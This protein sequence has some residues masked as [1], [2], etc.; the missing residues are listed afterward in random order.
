MSLKGDKPVVLYSRYSMDDFYSKDF[1]YASSFFSGVDFAEIDCEKVPQ[2]CNDISYMK[3]DTWLVK[4]ETISVFSGDMCAYDFV[5]FIESKTGVVKSKIIDQAKPLDD[6]DWKKV[7]SLKQCTTVFFFSLK[8]R[9]SAILKKI[10]DQVTYSFSRDPKMNV[11]Y[12]DCDK[13]L[14]FC[15]DRG[16]YEAPMIRV[17]KNQNPYDFPGRRYFKDIM[18]FIC[19]TTERCRYGNGELTPESGVIRSVEGLVKK[20]MKNSDKESVINE[21][22]RIT[23]SSTYTI[24]MKGLLKKGESYLENE[25]KKLEKWRKTDRTSENIIELINVMNIF[26]KYRP[27]I[28]SNNEL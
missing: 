7:I 28:N 11:F 27:Y 9:Q 6:N 4:S 19:A 24:I 20:F 25:L 16:V 1:A 10:A 5:Q 18:K 8:D 15:I 13:N 21:I 14:Q 17:Y 2:V 3:I 12:F 22:S 26:A 23:D